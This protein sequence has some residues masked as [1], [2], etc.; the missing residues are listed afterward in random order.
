MEGGMES[1]ITITG[2]TIVKVGEV[3]EMKY[4]E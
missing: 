4:I 3:L 1:V 2:R